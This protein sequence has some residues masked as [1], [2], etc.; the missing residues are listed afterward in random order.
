MRDP[1]DLATLLFG[2]D[3]DVLP[4]TWV[5][6]AESYDQTGTVTS[7]RWEFRASPSGSPSGTPAAPAA[8]Q[9]HKQR[10]QAALPA[11]DPR[12][13]TPESCQTPEPGAQG[14]SRGFQGHPRA[15][16]SPP[17]NPIRI[18]RRR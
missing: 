14:R 8:T 12:P 1:L 2:P 18:R 16:W 4:G 3:L 17:W 11:A 13:A 9:A 10:S 6:A 7:R 15:G 5:V